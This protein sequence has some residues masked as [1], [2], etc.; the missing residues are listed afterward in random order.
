[1]EKQ[2]L[3]EHELLNQTRFN[4]IKSVLKQDVIKYYE[5]VKS[6]I[7]ITAQEFLINQ[8]LHDESTAKQ[9]L[10]TNLNLIEKCDEILDK[11]L[12]QI[13]DYYDLNTNNIKNDLSQTKDDYITQSCLF[14]RNDQLKK[15]L[16]K[17]PVGVLIIF[18]WSLSSSLDY[19]MRYFV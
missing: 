10:K 19:F 11:T 14:V 8:R 5:T 1:M 13:N 15:E 9:V 16:T 4:Q 7:D 3:N 12:K 6:E 18:D 2:T 17:L